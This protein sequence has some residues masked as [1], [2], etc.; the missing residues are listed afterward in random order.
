MKPTRGLDRL[1]LAAVARDLAQ[2]DLVDLVG[3]QRQGRVLLDEAAVEQVAA[4]HVD[5]AD[6]VAGV[7]QIFVLEEVAQPPIGRDRCRRG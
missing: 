6:A 2:A 1:H 7:R 3:G 5:E 4:A